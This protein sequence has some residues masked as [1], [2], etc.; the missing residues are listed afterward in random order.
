VIFAIVEFL[1]L[2]AL[3]GFLYYLLGGIAMDYLD[4]QI[5]LYPTA[6]TNASIVFTKSIVNWLLLL[7]IIGGVFGLIVWVQRT[8]PEG[9]YR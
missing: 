2:I 6:F 4:S 3:G 9:Y 5:A 1:C 8:R 7:M